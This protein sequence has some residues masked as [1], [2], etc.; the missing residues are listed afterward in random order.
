MT[1]LCK[2]VQTGANYADDLALFTNTPAQT[3]SQLHIPVQ[4]VNGIGLGVNSV[5]MIREKYTIH[6]FCEDT[7]CRRGDLLKVMVNRGK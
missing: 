1:S 2:L 7:E 4:E 3:E 5:L 6:H